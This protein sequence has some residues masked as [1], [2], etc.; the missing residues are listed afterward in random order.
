MKDDAI[1]ATIM[2]TTEYIDTTT[3]ES[4]QQTDD[5]NN[6]TPE[7]QTM[8]EIFDTTTNDPTTSTTT[9]RSNRKKRHINYLATNS[10]ENNAYTMEVLVAVDRRMQEYHG[11]NL[12][13]YVLTLMS[14]VSSIY[15]DASI[16]NSINVAVVHILLLNDDL[17][18][19]PLHGGK[20]NVL[21][22]CFFFLFFSSGC[23]QYAPRS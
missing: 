3:F 1:D 17:R 5:L 23:L 18:S 13:Q 16:G 12:K 11:Q 4:T 15:A 20:W 21:F 9:Q 7:T 14:I 10:V 22:L 6:L 8:D 2:S 19:K